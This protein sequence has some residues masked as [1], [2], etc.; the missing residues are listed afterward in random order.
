MKKY[1]CLIAGISVILAAFLLYSALGYTFAIQSEASKATEA[2]F[3]PSD[4]CF[5]VLASYISNATEVDC[6]LYALNSASILNA[7]KSNNA[8][9]V[10][11]TELKGIN[12]VVKPSYKKGLMHNK[13]CVLDDSIVITGSFNP[14]ENSKIYRNNVAVLYSRVLAK[15]YS[16]EF[17]ELWNGEFGG[18]AKGSAKVMINNN[19]A[20]AYFC[21]EDNCQMHLIEEIT[22]AN[23]S[24]Y[25]M[26]YSFTDNDIADELLGKQEEGVIVR[27][28]FDKSQNSKWSVYPMLEG[29]AD[30]QVYGMGVLHHKVFIIDNETVITGSY[31]PTNNGNENNDENMLV[32]HDKQIAASFLAEFSRISNPKAI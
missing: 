15:A 28:F 17:E 6:A 7:L 3:C 1:H 10:S 24:I 4:D 13:F 5:N 18:G 2:Y 29:K 30:V 8:R 16:K 22:K 26:T 12:S 23:S 9:L 31:N 32:L 21:P 25:F 14:N 19:Q 11:D 27:G 20:E